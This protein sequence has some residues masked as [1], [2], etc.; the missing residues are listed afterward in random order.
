MD[1][2]LRTKRLILKPLCLADAAQIQKLFPQWEVVQF[3]ANRVPWPY[4]EEGALEYCRDIALPQADRGEAWHW[5]LRLMEEPGQ[6]IG[7]ISLTKGDDDNRGFW[8]GVP[9]RG[10][11]LMSEAC[12]AVNYFWFDTLCFPVMRIPKA[13]PNTASR[14]IS[15]KQ[16]MRVVA[17]FEKDFVCGRLPAEIWE[18]TADEWRAFKAGKLQ[19]PPTN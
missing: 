12:A 6:V 15:Q 19:P 4:P 3:L 8:L 17:Q 16:G 7:A 11:G 13:E 1:S 10:R 2:E 18:I 9:W 5:T 14:R